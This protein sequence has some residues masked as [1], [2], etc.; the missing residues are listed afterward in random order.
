MAAD[1]TTIA[2][3]VETQIKIFDDARH[4]LQLSIAEIARQAGVPVQTVNA[5]AQGRNNLTLWGLKKL[6]RVKRLAPLLSRLFDPEEYALVAVIAGI[7]HDKIAE[8]FREYLAEKDRAHHPES[9][10][11]RDIAPCE[12]NVL[13]VRFAAVAGQ[14]A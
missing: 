1:D 10:D 11:G 3:I 8:T 4:D 13:R 12:D 9:P 2:Y 6:L 5:W 14:A 7:D